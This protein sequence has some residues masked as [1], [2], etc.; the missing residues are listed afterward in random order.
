MGILGIGSY[1]PAQVMTNSDWE[2]YCGASAERITE[3][4]GIKKRRI[5][6]QNETTVD[7]AAKAAED[8]LAK[9]GV[10]RGDLTE[11]IVATD[12]PEA[13]APDTAAYLQARLQLGEIPAYDLAGSGCAGFILGLSLAASRVRDSG[14]KAL[15]IAVE[16]ISRIMDWHEPRIAPLFG[17]GAGA[18]I[19]GESEHLEILATYNATDGSGADALGLEVGGTRAPVTPER[20]ARAEHKRVVLQGERVY[21][22]AIKRMVETGQSLLAR[23]G[24]RA[25]DIGLLI[26][27]QANIHL[28]E[29]VAK[30]LG[31]PLERVVINLDRYGDTGSAAF[32]IALDE[33]LRCGRIKP[34]DHVLM[35]AF[36]MGFHWGGAVIRY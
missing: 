12:T 32:P 14:G 10:A 17:D 24:L 31:I 28:I 22:N 6:A 33:A 27:G 13:F 19:V 18:A 7:L 8:A 1:L 26:P 9:S 20:V 4:T 11:L 21:R 29:A 15:V 34:G 3:R 16:L 2:A 35:V 30:G 36:G 25:E 23:T 5:A